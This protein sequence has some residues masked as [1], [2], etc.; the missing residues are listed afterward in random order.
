MT[1]STAPDPTTPSPKKPFW[2][3]H[4][5]TAGI[6]VFAL[7]FVMGQVR[8]VWLPFWIVSTLGSAMFAVVMAGGA[9]W[10]VARQQKRS[11]RAWGETVLLVAVA[12]YSFWISI[13]HLTE[14][15]AG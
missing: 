2:R 8:G 5:W 12:A 15:L 9:A 6:V 11:A 4:I 7:L 10:E 3:R 14:E 13:G 1:T